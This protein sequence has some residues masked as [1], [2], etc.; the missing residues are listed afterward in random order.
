[1]NEKDGYKE[2]AIIYKEYASKSW[3]DFTL[4]PEPWCTQQETIFIFIQHIYITQAPR[5]NSTVCDFISNATW[6]FTF[7]LTTEKEQWYA[8]DIN[9][10]AFFGF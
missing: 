4:L 6:L 2:T 7:S 9:T 10:V 1:M 3:V 5:Q 8:Q